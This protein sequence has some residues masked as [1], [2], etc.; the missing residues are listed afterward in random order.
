MLFD[1]FTNPYASSPT[2]STINGDRKKLIPAD[3]ANANM[4]AAML[5]AN[6]LFLVIFDCSFLSFSNTYKQGC[7]T[8]TAYFLKLC[9]DLNP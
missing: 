8:K 1:K 6:C 2:F 3:T 4:L 7:R 5:I 9:S